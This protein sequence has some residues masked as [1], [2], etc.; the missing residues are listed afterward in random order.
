[1]NFNKFLTEI[2]RFIPRKRIY[3]DELRRLA[4]GTDASFY[5]LIPKIIIRAANE[6]EVSR[7]LSIADRLHIAVTFRA[8]GTSLSGQAISDSVLVVAGKHWEKYTILPGATAIRLQPGIIGERVNALLKPFGRKF[9]PDPA[10]VK[11]AMV[12]GIVMNNASGMNCGVHA[13]SD[14]ILLSAR[15]VLADGTVL[16]TGDAGSRTSFLQNRPEFIREIN[17]LRDRVRAD[18]S[19]AERIHRKYAIKNVTGLNLL[20]FVTY[21]DP[22]DI[23]AHLLAGSEGTLAFLSEA[24]MKT[25]YDFPFKA[26]AMLYFTDV[27]EACRAVV[28]MKKLENAGGEPIVK[29]AELLDGKSLKSVNDPA[30]EGLTAVL[31]ETKASSQQE[32]D[33]HIAEIKAALRHFQTR[34]PVCFTDRESEY[35]RYWAIRSG[36]FPSVGGTRQ[37]GTTTLIEDVAFH[38]EDLP[39]ATADLQQLMVKHHYSDACIYGHALEGNYHFIINQSFETEAEVKRYEALMNDVVKLVVD[40]Y[41]GSLKAEHGTGRNMAPFVE[42]EWGSEAYG[43]MKA[44]KRLFDPKQLLNPGVIFNDDPQCHLKNFKP[45]PLIHPE[46]DKCIECGFCEVNCLT[47]GLTLSSRQRIVL[48]REIGRLKASG[49]NPQRLRTL[50]KQYRYQ[51]NQTCAGD[52]LCAVSCPMGINAGELTRSI[53]RTEMPAGSPGY[54]IGEFAAGHFSP[55]KNGLRAVLV[56]ADILHTLLGTEIMRFAGRQLHTLLH[57]PLWTPAM[58]KSRPSLSAGLS[59]RKARPASLKAV[60]FPSC[61]NQTMGQEKHSPEKQPLTD[62]MLSLLH[63]AGYEA[64]FPEK[65]DN[66]C[67]GTIWESKGMPD[68][69]DRKTAELE[70]ALYE[71]SGQGKYPVLCDQSPCLYRMRHTITRMKLYEPVEFI[72]TFLLDRLEFTQ[73]DTPV[74]VHITCSMRKMGLEKQIVDLAKRC[75]SNVL[76]PEETGCCGFA[77]DKGFT[78][79]EVNAYALRKLRPQIEAA[80]IGRGYSNSRTC[81]IG[82]TTNSGI[83]YRSI[84]YLV[85]ECT[86]PLV[87]P[88]TH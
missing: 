69:A 51:G 42:R 74:A 38:I 3:T 10:S 28:A 73:T 87:N 49:G 30:G 26:S 8:A 46:I 58:P 7:L 44:V 88:S 61:I 71:A 52:G 37:P 84:V 29:S 48:Q 65:M 32:L 4:Y 63:K 76:I 77:G 43:I 36:I 64:I 17:S 53:R 60:Y 20:P 81:E 62:T 41:D 16:D 25:E 54:R 11:S 66:L 68:T 15:M 55:V 14:R 2:S 40:K 72:M 78:H 56:L 85:D 18:A 34:V 12:G 35:S 24:V 13:N 50:R 75:S 31:T 59:L 23:I 70:A 27:R 82:L 5:R 67:C 21:D 83:A 19:L 79:P 80:G 22:F 47:C 86:R 6:T 33:N 39:E 45:L 1:M 57:F 9:S